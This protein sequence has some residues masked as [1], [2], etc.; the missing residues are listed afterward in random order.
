MRF[1]K[2]LNRVKSTNV[3][4]TFGFNSYWCFKN[5]SVI[6]LGYIKYLYSNPNVMKIQL[7]S[8]DA[9]SKLLYL[10]TTSININTCGGRTKLL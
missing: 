2:D 5:P 8:T 10:I 3:I 9:L 4:E 1:S 6:V 7:F